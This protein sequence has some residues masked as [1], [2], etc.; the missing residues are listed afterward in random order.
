MA[1]IGIRKKRAW[2]AYGYA[3]FQFSNLLLV[4][5]LLLRPP[6]LSAELVATA[7]S[8]AVVGVALAVLFFFA[9]RSLAAAGSER[10]LAWPWIAV[11]AFFPLL[12]IF[13]Q[14]FVM[15]TGSMEDTM[16]IGD[17]ILVQR[18]P[19]PH[20]VRGDIVVFKYPVDPTQTFVKRVIGIGGDRIK[21]SDKT[22]YRNGVLLQ[23][24][25][26]VHK[27]DYVDS[28]RDNF[29]GEPNVSVD[30]RAFDMLTN[31]VVNGEVVV[32]EGAYFVLGDNRDSSLDSRYWGF[33]S[34]ADLLGKPLLIYESEDRQPNLLQS[35]HPFQL[36]RIRWDRFF[37]LL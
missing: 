6:A 26:A 5:I 24:P 10:G 16:L 30:K 12:L 33:V 8:S 27:T 11:S 29:P 13:V 4:A 15:P 22:L 2:A 28:Y 25:Y 37:R 18:F 35:D 1:G 31:H 3:L 23:E 32:P 36:G 17:H 9:G 21:I 7:V 34:A 14:A 20:P 19:A